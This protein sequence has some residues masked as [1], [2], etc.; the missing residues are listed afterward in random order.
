VGLPA[1]AIDKIKEMIVTGRLAP[2][3]RLPREQDLAAELGMSRNMLREA[4]TALSV[5]NVLD[6]RRG[7]GTYVTTL[8]PKL[9]LDALTF[10]ADFQRDDTVLNFIA[11]RKMLE[12]PATALA[13]TRIEP[14]ALAKLA[15][16]LETLR[17][18]MPV[19][20]MVITDAEFHRRIIDAAGN[21]ILS[22]VLET[23][24]RPLHR[25]RVWRKVLEEDAFGRTKTE[26][27][28]NPGRASPRRP[29][30]RQRLVAHPY[31][32]HR[33]VASRANRRRPGYGLGRVTA[34]SRVGKATPAAQ[35]G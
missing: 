27:S 14:E 9:L 23:V 5:I 26:A 10:I 17:E 15:D 29:R 12:P 13:A 31:I 11:V 35:T 2:G 22:S 3:D 32:G 8:S 25:A 7:D 4:V 21:P 1:E 6:V 20:D 24:S 33:A 19:D 28:G 30:G 16:H 18:D 34:G